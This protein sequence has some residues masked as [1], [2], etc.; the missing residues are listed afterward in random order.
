M[1]RGLLIKALRETFAVTLAIGLGLA[2]AEAVLAGVLPRFQEQIATLW[3]QLPFLRNMLQSILGADLAGR[4]GPEVLVSIAWVHPVIF[5]LVW[6]HAIVIC[7]RVPAG[8]VDRGTIDVLLGLPVSRWQIHIAEGSVWV[9]SGGAVIVLGAAGNI[10]G[11]LAGSV[12]PRPDPLRI[13]LIAANL[14]CLYLS[15]GSLTVLVASL[16]DRRG[17]AMGTAFAVVLASFLLNY[18]AQFWAPAESL[19]FLGALHYY[20]PLQILRDGAWPLRD[21]AVLIAS[22]AVLWIA[23][24]A[25]F[26]R[27]DL[28]TL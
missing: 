10:L 20:K 3:T 11:S 25:I 23:G 26:A 14:F 13:A 4:L 6:T 21:L 7:T 19:S 1:N 15:I 2:L 24:G 5:A 18:L 12:S 28:T 27:R 8:E 22:A 16:C 17:R 9:L